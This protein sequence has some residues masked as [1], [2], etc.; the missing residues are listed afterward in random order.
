MGTLLTFPGPQLSC[1]AKRLQSQARQST[2]GAKSGAGTSSKTPR[3]IYFKKFTWK[4]HFCKLNWVPKIIFIVFPAKQEICAYFRKIQKIQRKE[5]NF[6]CCLINC[7]F[8]VL[9][10]HK[11][12]KK[13]EDEFRVMWMLDLLA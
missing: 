4:C 11:S 1:P 12:F 7:I 3:I 10:E 2:V 6:L 5:E 9:G 13:H 8:N